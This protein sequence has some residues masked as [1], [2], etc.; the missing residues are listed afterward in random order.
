MLWSLELVVCAVCPIFW[1]PYPFLDH[2]V[3]ILPEPLVGGWGLM[4]SSDQELMT[5]SDESHP[6]PH[7][8][9]LAASCTW[10]SRDRGGKCVGVAELWA[11]IKILALYLT[12]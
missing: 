5:G 8:T 3:I 4:T 10:P 1:S 7:E 2:N 6:W 9:E 12:C 11:C